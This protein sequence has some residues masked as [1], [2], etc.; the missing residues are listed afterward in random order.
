MPRF[1]KTPIYCFKQKKNEKVSIVR[2]CYRSR[3]FRFLQKNAEA[4]APAQ[5]SAVVEEVVVDSAAVVDSSVV[6]E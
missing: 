5:D 6:A 2:R 3:F 1:Q 4:E